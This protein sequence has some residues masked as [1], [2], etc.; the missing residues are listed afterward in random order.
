[1]TQIDRL[2]R[3]MINLEPVEFVGLAHVMRVP[4]T[5]GLDESGHPIARPFT[6]VLDDLL[7]TFN[8]SNRKRRREILKIVHGAAS[9]KEVSADAGDTEDT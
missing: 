5:S 2:L 8:A 6:D 7:G 3:D 1:M 4:L 9:N